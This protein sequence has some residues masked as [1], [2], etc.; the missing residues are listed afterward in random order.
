MGTRGRGDRVVSEVAPWRTSG[1]HETRTTRDPGWVEPVGLAALGVALAVGAVLTAPRA[2][3][4]AGSEPGI[5]GLEL[6]GTAHA[7][8]AW[9][10]SYL[11]AD[12]VTALRWDVLFILCWAPLLAL[13]CWR[14]GRGY[15]TASTRRL[16]VPVAAA[17]LAAGALDLVEDLGLWLAI[18]G[19]PL[20]GRGRAAGSWL[21]S[22][23]GRS[24][25]SSSSRR[26]AF[27]DRRPGVGRAHPAVDPPG[28]RRHRHRAGGAG[29][30]H[31][32]LGRRGEGGPGVLRRRDPRRLDLARRAA[33]ARARR[34]PGLGHRRRRDVGQWRLVH[35]RRLERRPLRRPRADASTAGHLPPPVGP[36]RHPGLTRGGAPPRQPR[37]P[38]L[39]LS[40][41][42]GGGAAGH[43]RA[44][45]ARRSPA[46]VATVLTGMV[47]N[48]AV[49]LGLLFVGEPAAGVVLPLVLRPRLPDVAR[50]PAPCRGTAPTPASSSPTGS[51]RRCSRRSASASSS[52]CCGS[53]PPRR[54]SSAAACRGAWLLGLKYAGYGGLGSRRPAARA[55]RPAARDALALLATGGLPRPLEHPGHGGRG[56]RL[57]L[58]RAA[59]AAQAAGQDRPGGRR[60]PV[61][62]AAAL[63]GQPLGADRR[64]LRALGRRVGAVGGRGRRAARSSTSCRLAEAWSLAAFY[65]GKLRLGFATYRL[66]WGSNARGRRGAGVRQRRRRGRRPAPRTDALHPEQPRDRA[67]RHAADRLRG[68]D[69]D[70]ARG[71]H[72]LR[73][74]G[75]QRHLLP[76]PRAHVLAR[77]GQRAVARAGVHDRRDRVADA[78]RRPAADDVPGRRA[79]G[80]GGLPGDGSLPARAGQ[81]AADLRQR[82]ARDVGAQ[83]ALRLG[84]GPARVAAAAATAGL[85]AQGVRRDARPERP[86]PLRHRRRALGEHRARRAAAHR[87]P[88]RAGL[89]RRRLRPRQPGRLGLQGDRPRRSSSARPPSRSTSTSCAPTPTRHR[90]ATTRHARSTSASSVVPTA[91]RSGS[92]CSGTPSPR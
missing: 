45:R 83:P 72:P 85:P 55:A 92:P 80:R 2:D 44:A 90:G 66:P 14:L 71:A 11:A 75:D 63:P 49:L 52:S 91:A 12:V 51:D 47:V 48:A 70:R 30:L 50:A 1:R 42:G 33:G 8:A 82:A 69:G 36:G 20:D 9:G 89:H 29:R 46:A 38:A 74:P 6:M 60:D 58:G 5:L 32:A 59:A 27:A 25:W 23:R 22:A 43:R 65:R 77:G 88:P 57:R 37:L 40:A 28:P 21:R 53:A 84:P 24:G 56:G 62:A 18:D 17:V 35:D 31:A 79:V 26:S 68:G 81:H 87:P 16:A 54:P 41:R 4:P 39:E 73:H 19:G 7:A 3:L 61:R 67:G 10:D 78:A 15:R 64:P 76:R 13:L 86:L 34:R